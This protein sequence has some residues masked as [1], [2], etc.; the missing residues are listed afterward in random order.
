MRNCP[1]N[2][3]YVPK[4][5]VLGIVFARDTLI[6]LRL[7]VI[8]VMIPEDPNMKWYCGLF[9]GKSKSCRLKNEYG[10]NMECICAKARISYLNVI[11]GYYEIKR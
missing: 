5:P 4:S 7:P 3:I 9:Q 6:S 8:T 10:D 11:Y 2:I 1:V